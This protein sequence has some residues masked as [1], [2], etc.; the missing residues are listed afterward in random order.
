MRWLIESNRWKHLVG[1][2]VVSLFGTLLM[3]IGCIGGMEFKDVHHAN[4]DS[5]PIWQWDWS[6]WDWLDVLAGMI[7]G[8][9]GQALQVLMVWLAVK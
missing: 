9:I 5:K 2:F 8:V 1:I 6:A 3:G 7:G 4:G